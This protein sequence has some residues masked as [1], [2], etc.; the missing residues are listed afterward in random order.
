MFT[1]RVQAVIDKV[2]H[3][4]HEVD[5]HWQIPRDEAELLAQLVRIGRCESICE[6]GTSYGFSSLHLTA[7]MIEV[8]GGHLHTM[9]ID[10]RKVHAAT[11]HLAEA[12][13][14][15]HVTV[16]KGDARDVLTA[17]DPDRPF[18][19]VFIDAVKEQSFDYLH[20]VRPHL[21]DRAILVTDNTTTHAE[22]LSEFVAHLRGMHDVCSSHVP[23]GN[24][25]ELTYKFA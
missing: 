7:A 22:A 13:L 10:P 25:F 18:D 1:P 20:A 16:H 19:F 21:A 14:A 17:L 4:R 12:G 24:G 9:D 5:D 3:L 6:I 2:D 11:A 15:D 23:V 8:G